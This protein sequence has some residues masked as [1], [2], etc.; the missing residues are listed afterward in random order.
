[1][2]FSVIG[3]LVLIAACSSAPPPATEAPVES[4]PAEV[5]TI[6][7]PIRT[8]LAPLL[9]AIESQ[10]PKTVASKTPYEVVPK[11]P[12]AVRYRIAREPIT[13]NMQGSGLHVTTIVRYEL[14]SALAVDG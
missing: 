2:R 8:T 13:L 12:Y 10:V 3:S 7:I 5:S 6:V 4:A 11:Q 9:P 1:M 14:A